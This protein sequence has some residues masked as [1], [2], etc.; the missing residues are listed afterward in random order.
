M[1]MPWSG[2]V[3]RNC[4]NGDVGVRGGVVV[5]SGGDVRVRGGVVV[6]SGGYHDRQGGMGRSVWQ[7]SLF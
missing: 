6:M 2:G 3:S 4:Q 7:K 1:V 5:M